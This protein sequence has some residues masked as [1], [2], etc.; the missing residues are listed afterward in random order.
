[1]T[2]SPRSVGP[3]TL[4]ALVVWGHV[5]WIVSVR[6]IHG[7]MYGSLMDVW[8]MDGSVDR[9]IDR[10]IDRSIDHWWMDRSIDHGSIGRSMDRSIDGSIDGS[11]D[12][13]T[14]V[15]EVFISLN[16]RQGRSNVHRSTYICF[17]K[18]LLL[19]DR[20][21]LLPEIGWCAQFSPLWNL[22]NKTK[23]WSFSKFGFL[24]VFS[25]SPLVPGR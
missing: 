16:V 6:F 15:G 7:S 25:H 17:F 3:Y 24:I 2:L 9:W 23:F 8:I 19:S 21:P 12:P 22:I 10:S 11:V 5:L 14:P 20:E 18:F 4:S 13:L 1:M